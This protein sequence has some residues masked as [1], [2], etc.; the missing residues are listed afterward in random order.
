MLALVAAF[1]LGFLLGVSSAPASP[2]PRLRWHVFAFL[3]GPLS[4]L[5]GPLSVAAPPS[6]YVLA[7]VPDPVVHISAP[8]RRAM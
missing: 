5:L 4:F 8:V 3:L 7:P 1:L 2:R 6:D